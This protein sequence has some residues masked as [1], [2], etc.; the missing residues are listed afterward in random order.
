[1]NIDNLIKLRLLR[2]LGT[3]LGNEFFLDSYGVAHTFAYIKLFQSKIDSTEKTLTIDLGIYHNKITSLNI[4]TQP[5]KVISISFLETETEINNLTLPSFLEIFD[6]I[7]IR[8][9][10]FV[11]QEVLNLLMDWSLTKELKISDVFELETQS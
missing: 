6:S 9:D 1:M 2:K 8:E 11:T 4:D 7:I 5:I 3:D 10:L